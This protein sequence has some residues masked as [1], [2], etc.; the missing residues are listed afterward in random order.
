MDGWIERER[1]E[2][3]GEEEGLLWTLCSTEGF[4]SKIWQSA[5]RCT[6]R[7]RLEVKRGEESK[8]RGRRMDIKPRSALSQASQI[9]LQPLETIDR[10][11]YFLPV[12]CLSLTHTHTQAQM[13]RFASC[14]QIKNKKK[15]LKIGECSLMTRL[16]QSEYFMRPHHHHNV[17]AS[18]ARLQSSLYAREHFEC[19]ICI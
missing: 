5:L 8:D 16:Y 1:N 10:M 2:E 19:P 15:S 3:G 4:K 7:R 17:S 14:H 18:R 6:V 11:T 13:G 9:A 12:L